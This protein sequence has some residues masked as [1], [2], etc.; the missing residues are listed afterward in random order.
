MIGSGNYH[1]E[2]SAVLETTQATAVVLIVAGGT[3]GSGFS[4]QAPRDLLPSLPGI[5]RDLANQIAT[6]L[7]TEAA[8][9]SRASKS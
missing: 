9:D 2:C 5:L 6:D 3:K 4:V 8:K 1:A 7:W